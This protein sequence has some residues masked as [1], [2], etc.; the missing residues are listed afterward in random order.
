M[1][2]SQFLEILLFCATGTAFVLYQ[3]SNNKQ[4]PPKSSLTMTLRD[5]LQQ[6]TTLNAKERVFTV[7]EHNRPTARGHLRSEMRLQ[8]LWHRATYIIIRHVVEEQEEEDYILV[9]RRSHLKDYCPNTLDPAPGGVVGF[10]ESYE[11]NAKR[12][13]LEEMNIAVDGDYE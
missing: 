1:Q 9:Q 12:E 7:D 10:Q 5:K 8:N 4:Q 2:Q 6:G 3:N 13:L 11:T